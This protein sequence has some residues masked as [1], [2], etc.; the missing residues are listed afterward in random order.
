MH[1]HAV[2]G[3]TARAGLL[4]RP[5]QPPRAVCRLQVVPA[6]VRFGPLV[7]AHK[8]RCDGVSDTSQRVS[9]LRLNR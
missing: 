5:V 8:Q 7:A 1:Q 3:G 6:K 4:T 2:R 9:P